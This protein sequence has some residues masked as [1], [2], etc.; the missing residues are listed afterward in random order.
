MSLK[1]LQK[2]KKLLELINSIGC[3]IPNQYAKFVLCLYTNDKLPEKEIK[4]TIPLIIA[5]KRKNI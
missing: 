4:K 2:K 5:A 3:R 1:I